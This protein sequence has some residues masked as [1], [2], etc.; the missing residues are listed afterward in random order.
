[1]NNMYFIPGSP[2]CGK[3]TLARRL[4]EKHGLIYVCCDDY[5]DEFLLRGQ[6]EGIPEIAQLAE[7]FYSSLDGM[8]L[9]SAQELF[10][11]ELGYYEAAFSWLME[12]LAETDRPLIAEGAA[13]LPHRLKELG[14]K[15]NQVLCMIPTED[16][17]RT[18][19][20]RREWVAPYLAGCSDPETAFDNWMARDALMADFAAGMAS[21]AG[22]THLII[23]GKKDLNAVFTVA[24]QHFD[25]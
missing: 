10:S 4:A 11:D 13:L 8:W 14:I 20:A 17:Q 12:K 19:Y 9:R 1:M 3:S 15:E 6:R 25:L 21:K 16:F 5:Q 23:D 22:Y 2:C 24:E 7:R 18:Q